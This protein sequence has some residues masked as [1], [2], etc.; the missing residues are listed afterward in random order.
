MLAEWENS[1]VSNPICAHI[2]GFGNQFSSKL[3]SYAVIA[4]TNLVRDLILTYLAKEEIIRHNTAN[5]SRITTQS[6][7][8]A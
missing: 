3:D 1:L 6:C 2:D 7:S 5:V 4:V 8:S